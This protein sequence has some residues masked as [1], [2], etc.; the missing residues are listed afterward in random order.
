[1]KL[2]PCLRRA[3]P[4]D[5]RAVEI[6]GRGGGLHWESL[7]LDLSVPTLLSLNPALTRMAIW[8]L[9]ANRATFSDITDHQR[10]VRSMPRLPVRLRHVRYPAGETVPLI[11]QQTREASHEL[12]S[13]QQNCH[14]RWSC[15]R[16]RRRC[17][18]RHGTGGAEPGCEQSS[19]RS[20]IE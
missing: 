11:H 7:D 6:V 14:W 20:C 8:L 19:D 18:A 2:V 1:M 3:T 4:H 10:Q 13:R 17:F 9:A 12:T 5:V 15:G 16:L